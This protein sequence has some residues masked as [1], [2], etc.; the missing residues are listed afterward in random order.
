MAVKQ[1][2]IALVGNEFDF[3]DYQEKS[4]GEID[5]FSVGVGVSV[6]PGVSVRVHF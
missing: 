1:I 5:I 6:N 4:F 2:S 3:Q